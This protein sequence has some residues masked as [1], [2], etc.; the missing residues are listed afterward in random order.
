MT[1]YQ[2]R[3]QGEDNTGYYDS[4]PRK[5]DKERTIPVTMTA[6]QE[7]RTR[8]GQY[9]YYDSIPRKTNKERT[10]PVTMTAYQERLIRR[11]KVPKDEEN[12]DDSETNFAA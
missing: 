6:Y 10:I 4:I 12:G 3:Q 7:R 5:T 8:R 1:A 9:C 11:G 2:E